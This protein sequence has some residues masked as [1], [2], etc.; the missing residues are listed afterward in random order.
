[1]RDSPLPDQGRRRFI[2]G[3]GGVGGALGAGLLG[4]AGEAGA[5]APLCALTPERAEGPFYIDESQM[6][7][8][9]RDRRPGQPLRLRVIVL[10]TAR[11]CARVAG[12]VASI[13][14]C[15]AGGHYS[16]FERAEPP[17][18]AGEASAPVA[19]APVGAQRFLRGAQATR[20]DG[21]AQFLTIYP[22]WYAPRAVHIHLKI[23]LGEHGVLTTQMFFDDRLSQLVHTSHPAYRARG[24]S[25]V[26][27]RQDP[28]AGAHPGFV[29]VHRPNE[30]G[31]LEGEFLVGVARP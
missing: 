19:A 31:L 5:V 13:W 12:A 27:V 26:T 22:G 6:R 14:H 16:G 18:A 25:P 17:P 21:S 11:N 1:M 28:L 30:S 24:P 23:H 8:D 4:L 2:G 9:I 15:D 20:R 10:D 3:L 29:M 7:S